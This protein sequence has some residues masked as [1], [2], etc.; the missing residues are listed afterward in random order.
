[1]AASVMSIGNE[2][3]V[4][5]PSSSESLGLN[6]VSHIVLSSKIQGRGARRIVVEG[7]ALKYIKQ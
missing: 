3:S 5:L 6:P 4:A 1:M 2:T 7:Q